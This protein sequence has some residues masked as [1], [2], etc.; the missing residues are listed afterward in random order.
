M[1]QQVLIYEI[2]V[3]SAE[4]A[5]KLALIKQNILLVCLARD[6]G[7]TTLPQL[8]KPKGN[9]YSQFRHSETLIL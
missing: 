7:F 2:F 4:Q 3:I 8:P 6:P 5:F 9:F 1:A